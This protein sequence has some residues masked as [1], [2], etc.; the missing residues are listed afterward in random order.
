MT[1]ST[2]KIKPKIKCFVVGFQNI[3]TFSNFIENSEE[4][5]DIKDSD[6]VIFTGGSDINPEIYG[7]EK[8]TTTTGIDKFRDQYEITMF[9]IAKALKKNMFGICRGAQLL[10]A[11]SGAKLVQHQVGNTSSHP[12]ITSQGEEMITTHAH[13]QSLDLRYLEKEQYELLAWDNYQSTKC[14]GESW[15]DVVKRDRHPEYVFFPE[16]KALAFQ[17][18]PEWMSG[19]EFN[20]TKKYINET[21]H[22]KL[23]I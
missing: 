18:H 23:K 3:T 4:V 16:T 6:I 21:I 10:G 9:R 2:N 7:S 20:R 15:I 5:L 11:L 17:G 8:H 1:E 19:P 13:H 22:D 14:Y 12:M